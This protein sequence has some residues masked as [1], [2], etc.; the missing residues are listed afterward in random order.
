MMLFK[1]EEEERG[2]FS[3]RVSFRLQNWSQEILSNSCPSFD[4]AFPQK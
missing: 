1:E 3:S 2:H 4:E